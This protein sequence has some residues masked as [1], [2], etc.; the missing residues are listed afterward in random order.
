[1]R[2]TSSRSSTALQP[3]RAISFVSSGALATL[4]VVQLDERNDVERLELAPSALAPH[5]APG[6]MIGVAPYAS[7]SQSGASDTRAPRLT[8]EDTSG[9]VLRPPP[10]ATASRAEH[11]AAMQS[12]ATARRSPPRFGEGSRV[13]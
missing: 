1:M 2:R 3:S 12:A 11:G 8:M 9:T 4:T 6:C 7:D 13:T 10:A 5:L